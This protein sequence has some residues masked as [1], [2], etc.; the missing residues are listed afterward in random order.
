MGTVELKHD[1]CGRYIPPSFQRR[2]DEF[3]KAQ[4]NRF[5][6]MLVW[7]PTAHFVVFKGWHLRTAE[8]VDEYEGR[9]EV[10]IRWDETTHPLKSG[11]RIQD[12]RVV[13]GVLA[14]KLCPWEHEDE[15]YADPFNENFFRA[16]RVANSWR[17]RRHYEESHGT[18]AEHDAALKKRMFDILWP[19]WRDM[20]YDAV[21]GKPVV[22][23]GLRR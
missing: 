16:A 2:L 10:W 4:G 20:Y 3:N 7:N 17:S 9:W 14:V 23:Q 8:R 12:V 13:N 21:K 22:V 5:P 11:V 6:I 19:V 1:G 15:S 18:E